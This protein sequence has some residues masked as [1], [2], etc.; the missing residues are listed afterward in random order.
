MVGLVGFIDPVR[1]E[2]VFAI[3]ECNNA[4]IKTVMITGDHPLT[5]FHIGKE[6]NIAS[7]YEEVATE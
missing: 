7:I 3:K 5:A 6:L 1:E 4:K 2:V